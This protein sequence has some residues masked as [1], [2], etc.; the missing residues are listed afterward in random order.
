MYDHE[1]NANRKDAT[2]LFSD[3]IESNTLEKECEGRQP[4]L[5]KGE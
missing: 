5:L 2:A 4:L 3:F 1:Q